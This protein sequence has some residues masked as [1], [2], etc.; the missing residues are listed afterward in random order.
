MTIQLLRKS[1]Y[2]KDL[3]DLTLNSV[4]HMH[5]VF[6]DSPE[7]GMQF[8]LVIF[9]ANHEYGFIRDNCKGSI[10]FTCLHGALTLEIAERKPILQQKAQSYKLYP[11]DILYLPRSYW[12]KTQS[13]EQG[14][15]FTE[16]IEG[17]YDKINRDFLYINT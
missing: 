8:M 13:H 16:S 4:G 2:I 11:G 12:R 17:V 3:H 10:S 7:S 5:R 9:E 6:H 15:I 14:A 1:Q